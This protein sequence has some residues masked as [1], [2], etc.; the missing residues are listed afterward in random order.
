MMKIPWTEYVTNVVLGKIGVRRR[1]NK[2]TLKF[3]ETAEISGPYNEER[4][5]AESDTHMLK[6]RETE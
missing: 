6:A 3:S 4:E 1:E 5:L 2:K